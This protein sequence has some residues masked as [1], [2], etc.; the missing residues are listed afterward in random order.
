MALI[1]WLPLCK[2]HASRQ[3]IKRKYCYLIYSWGLTCFLST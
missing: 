2:Q 1:D 3:L